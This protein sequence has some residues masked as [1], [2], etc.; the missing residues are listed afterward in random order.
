MFV[1]PPLPTSYVEILTHDV[2]AYGNGTLVHEGGDLI[3]WIGALIQ[4]APESSLALL[5]LVRQQQEVCNLR[6]PP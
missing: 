2:M 5:Y 4:E 1:S 6:E 3:N